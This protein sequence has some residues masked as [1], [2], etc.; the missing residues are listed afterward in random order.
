MIDMHRVPRDAKTSDA[1]DAALRREKRERRKALIRNVAQL[2]ATMWQ[3]PVATG[4]RDPHIDGWNAGIEA[5]AIGLSVAIGVS[6]DTGRYAV[7][8]VDLTRR[9]SWRYRDA[10]RASDV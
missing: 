2:M 9:Y 3:D 6:L 5:M 1:Y 7:D 10:L 4:R 8:T